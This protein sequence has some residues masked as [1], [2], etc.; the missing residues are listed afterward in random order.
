MMELRFTSSDS[1]DRS[2][3]LTS[4]KTRVPTLFARVKAF[5]AGSGR[6]RTEKFSISLVI[7]ESMG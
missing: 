5:V 2:M 7:G 3:L 1:F 6:N 4:G